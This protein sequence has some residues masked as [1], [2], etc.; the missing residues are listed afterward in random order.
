MGKSIYLLSDQVFHWNIV[1]KTHMKKHSY[2]NL[3]KL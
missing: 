2:G 1:P 3:G